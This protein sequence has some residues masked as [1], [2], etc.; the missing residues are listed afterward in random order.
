M[1]HNL[2][3]SVSKKPKTGGIVAC[4]TVTMREKIMRLFFG[5]PHKITILVPGD[6]VDTVSIS[7]IKEGG[8]SDE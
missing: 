8:T 6:T 2:S 4:R 1:K 3:I 7:E 5:L